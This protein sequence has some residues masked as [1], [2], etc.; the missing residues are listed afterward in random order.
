MISGV[1]FLGL[2]TPFR[3]GGASQ[4]I[5]FLQNKL[6]TQHSDD[7]DDVDVDGDGDDDDEE[8]D[9]LRLYPS[10]IKSRQQRMQAKP[11]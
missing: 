7:D 5:S 1:W 4:V 9:Y 2:V 3:M 6:K 10:R 11:L 8:I